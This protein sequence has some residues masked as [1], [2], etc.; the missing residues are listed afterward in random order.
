MVQRPL[1]GEPKGLHSA[2]EL[3]LKIRVRVVDSVP[4]SRQQRTPPPAL[5]TTA[6]TPKAKSSGGYAP[7]AS[8]GEL[9]GLP[10]IARGVPGAIKGTT[11]GQN[12]R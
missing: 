4:R 3:R 1:V 5:L 9:R 6:G 8:P 11:P 10:M 7:P 2:G 12:L